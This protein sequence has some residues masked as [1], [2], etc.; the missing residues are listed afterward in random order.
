MHIE[1]PTP[2]LPAAALAACLAVFPGTATA[3]T[4]GEMLH[5]LNAALRNQPETYNWRAQLDPTF[6]CWRVGCSQNLPVISAAVALIK[7]PIGTTPGGTPYNIYNWWHSFLNCQNGVSCN[8]SP[9]GS[10]IYFK[11]SEMMSNTYDWSVT[12]AVA[13]VNW[14]AHQNGDAAMA[15]EARLY[16][17]KTWVV[18]ALAAGSSY[19]RQYRDDIDD[20]GNLVG[21]GTGQFTHRCQL[22][23]GGTPFFD[24]PFLPLAS[25]RSKP[26]AYC[27]DNRGVLLAKAVDWPLT[28]NNQEH[29]EQANLRAYI[30][31]NWP[32][33][34]FGESVYAL[35]VSE[36]SLVRD[37][38]NNGNQVPAFLSV[39]NN[40]N[41]RFRVRM[42]FLGW[43]GVRVSLIEENA[44]GNAHGPLYAAKYDRSIQEAHMLYPWRPS[45]SS[46][47]QKGYGRLLPTEI[48]P[49]EVEASNTADGETPPLNHGGL[50]I[51]RFSVPSSTPLYH[52]VV[53]PSAPA[54]QI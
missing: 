29:Q 14:W 11:G 21:D 52:V 32:G 34:A 25:P 35:S 26:A 18:Y 12:A 46:G 49:T 24:G 31:P 51:L 2:L 6:N 16:L 15:N 20:A 47:Y 23:T 4:P 7:A 39:L 1:K 13:A 41:T 27:A 5:E 50:H 17:R 44:N 42:H 45:A 10:L 33:N 22:N 54:S 53:G 38:I 9:A 8:V 48:S 43:P 3:T 40:G 36:R 37:H 19:A 30:E 28:K